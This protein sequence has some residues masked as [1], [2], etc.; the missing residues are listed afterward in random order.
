MDG[1][2]KNIPN[3]HI[4]CNQVDNKQQHEDAQHGPHIVYLWLDPCALTLHILEIVAK[5]TDESVL[6]ANLL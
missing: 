3:P 2:K 5:A 4:L 6:A 1:Y